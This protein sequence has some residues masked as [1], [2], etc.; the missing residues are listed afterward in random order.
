L[1]SHLRFLGEA[2]AAYKSES[3]RYKQVAGELRVLVAATRWNRPL[4]LDLMDEFGFKYE[5]HP[6]PDLPFP[7]TMVGDIHRPPEVDFTDMSADEIWAYH[8]SHGRP[9]P[10]REFVDR[11]LAVYVAPHEFSYRELILGV[12]Q[13][14]GVSHED[15]TVDEALVHLEGFIIGGYSGYGAPLV[16]VANL[17]FNAGQSL[18]GML[19]LAGRYVRQFPEATNG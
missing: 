1:E 14:I 8:R 12:A 15:P 4:L 5:V 13:Q 3:D 19:V 18:L 16:H 11:A 2:L 17:V 7:I 6:I 10:L 9:V